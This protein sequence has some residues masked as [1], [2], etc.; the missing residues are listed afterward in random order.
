VLIGDIELAKATYAQ[1]FSVW[2]K[3]GLLPE[4]FQWDRMTIHSTE[5]YYPLRPELIESTYHLFASTHDPKYRIA[6]RYMFNS[7][8]K[9]TKVCGALY[10]EARVDVHTHWCRL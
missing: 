7:L 8:E 10:S 3:Y 6:G 9:H 5:R 2:H 4:R 1:F